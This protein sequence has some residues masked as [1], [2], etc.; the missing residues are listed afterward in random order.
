MKALNIVLSDDQLKDKQLKEE[1]KELKEELER[2]D[3]TGVFVSSKGNRLSIVFQDSFFEKNK[4]NSR[5]A[6]RHKKIA[7]TTGQNTAVIMYSN[8]VYKLIQGATL[9]DMLQYTGL[10]QATYYRHLQALKRSQY[11]KYV[12]LNNIKVLE[13]LEAIEGNKVF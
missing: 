3:I 2:N 9:D 1:L 13:D 8:V 5:D 7:T 11:Y 6:G 12:T 4:K 10:A